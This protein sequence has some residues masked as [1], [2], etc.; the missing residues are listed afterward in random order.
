LY[1]CRPVQVQD[2]LFSW[3][4]LKQA[5]NDESLT[6]ITADGRYGSTPFLQPACELPCVCVVR[7]RYDRVLYT[8]PPPYS[9]FGRP[10]VHGDK[11]DF[12]EPDTW[13]HP[14]ETQVLEHD[15]YG[16]VQL[17]VWHDLHAKNAP[18]AWFS[19]IR[20]Q[21][22]CE[23]SDK[24]QVRWLA[25]INYPDN[26]PLATIWQW[27]DYRYSIEPNFRFRKQN[28]HW[29]CPNFQQTSTC[30]YWT[31]LIDIALGMLY[32]AQ[33]CVPDK[34]LP[35]QPSQP[36]P[37]PQRVKQAL[38]I[39]LAR[40]PTLTSPPKPRGKSTGWQKGRQRTRPIRHPVNIRSP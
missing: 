30:D 3:N 19:V 11:F 35:W 7:L 24:T 8:A 1:P 10:R 33:H 28:P 37:T 14:D 15:R 34:P 29:T 6:V 27:Y 2:E 39:L 12:E 32:L 17:Q 23:D 25:V 5:Q 13:H 16:Q 4:S 26:Y 21:V 9:G 18:Q 22:H 31:T 38:P 20:A 40:L 36:H